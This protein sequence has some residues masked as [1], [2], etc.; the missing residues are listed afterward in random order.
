VQFTTSSSNY[1]QT[2]KDNLMVTE[3]MY[4]P[5]GP[6]AAEVGYFEG[7][8]EFV[9][10]MNI[11]T[12]LTL[13]LSNVRFTK[14]IDFNFAGSAITSLAPGARVVVVKNLAAFTLRYGAGRPVAGAWDAEDNLSNGGEELKVSF[15][16]GDGIQEFIYDNNSPWPEQADT[17]GYSLVLRN[18]TA[19]PDHTLPASWRASLSAHGTP[20]APD[21]IA[22]ADW[23]GTYGITGELNDPDRDGMVNL[24]EYTF[25]GIPTG[26][27]GTP[28]PTVAVQNFTVNGVP[29]NY[30]TVTFRRNLLAEDLQ[31]TVP[32]STDLTN[33][34]LVGVL[35]N[36]VPNTDGTATQTW[37]SPV[38]IS[39]GVKQF[40]RVRALKP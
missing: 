40:G 16:S 13:D 38:P 17:G 8:F 31:V 36:S 30:L 5:L 23:A 14:G 22:F 20:G 4:R 3:F 6:S 25:A 35:A 18:P 37:R 27:S 33:W 28:L 15:G 32:F 29:G 19:R 10:L 1:V 12:S 24:L 2:L 39:S 21:R 9:E 26:N 7:D 34:N 11:S